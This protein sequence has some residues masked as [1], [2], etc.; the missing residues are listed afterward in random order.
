MADHGLRPRRQLPSEQ[1]T[2]WSGRPT[3]S[4]SMLKP[5]SL[6]CSYLAQLVSVWL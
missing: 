4:L 3:R 5:S 6:P 1:L 2:M